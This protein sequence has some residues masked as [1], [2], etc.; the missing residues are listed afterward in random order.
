M[1]SPSAL[2][3]LDYSQ[4]DATVVITFYTPA[5]N[6]RLVAA[7]ARAVD[8]L[9]ASAEVAAVVFTGHKNVFMTGADV[10]EVRRLHDATGVADFLRIPHQL[11][12][13]IQSLDKV[14]TAA[15]NG[16]CLGGGLELA[17]TC[18]FRILADDLVDHLGRELAYLGLPEVRLGLVPALGGVATLAATV[19]RTHATELLFGGG[20]ITAARALEVGLADLAAPRASLLETALSRVN[21]VLANSRPA[22]QGIKRLLRS[23]RGSNFVDALRDA[24]RE[25]ASC[26]T[27]GDKDARI[28]AS[29]GE[30]VRSFGQ[31]LTGAGTTA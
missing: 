7:L 31:S 1:S 9:E 2:D 3:C 6:R 27:A 14:V 4:S 17:L 11:M 26:C 25:F 16:Y 12:A 18:D 20:L 13:R 21:A 10:G 5:L 19:G 8:R 30:R 22:L 23:S 15:I 24:E 28:D 29:R